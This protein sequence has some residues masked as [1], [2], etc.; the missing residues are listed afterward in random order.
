MAGDRRA[1]ISVTMPGRKIL[2]EIKRDYH[3][4]VDDADGGLERFYAHDPDAL[5]VGIYVV[6]WFADGRPT[7][8][9]LPPDAQPRLTSPTKWK[10]CCVHV[11]RPTM[12]REPPFW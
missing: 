3:S 7:T 8:I 4:D 5:G 10:R 6:F 12:R 1:D 9:P 11:F 2:C